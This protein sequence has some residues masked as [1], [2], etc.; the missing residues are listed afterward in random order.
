MYKFSKNQY[1]YYHK[2]LKFYVCNKLIINLCKPRL[3][4]KEYNA[5][6]NV[7]PTGIKI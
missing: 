3:L 5:L 4:H 2:Q 1:S 7:K 6:G